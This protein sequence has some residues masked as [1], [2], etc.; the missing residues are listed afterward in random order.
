MNGIYFI[1]LLAVVLAG[2]LSRRIPAA[3]AKWGLG[4]GALFIA[5]CYFVPPFSTIVTAFNEY[6]FLGL[7]FLYLLLYMFAWGEIAPREEEFVQVDVKAVDLTPWRHAKLTGAILLLVV[8]AVYVYF[9]D[10]SVL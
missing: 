6:T 9:A 5:F 2:M 1:P 3:A 8:V 10:T 7:V 4:G